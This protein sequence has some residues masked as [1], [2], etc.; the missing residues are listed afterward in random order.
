ME[1]N[2]THKDALSKIPIFRYCSKSYEIVI[3]QQKNFKL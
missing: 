3:L 1:E 2:I